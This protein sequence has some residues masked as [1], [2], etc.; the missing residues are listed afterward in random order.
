[1]KSATMICVLLLAGVCLA[2]ASQ[3]CKVDNGGGYVIKLTV[4]YFDMATSKVESWQ[5]NGVSLGF[6]TSYT[7]PDTALG[8]DCHANIVMAGFPQI[9]N[10]HYDS[11]DDMLATC[12]AYKVWGTIFVP[13]YGTTC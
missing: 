7:F 12:T 11:V 8:I 6:S 3:S 13:Y 9:Y 2:N 1:M 10:V 5:S 4:Q